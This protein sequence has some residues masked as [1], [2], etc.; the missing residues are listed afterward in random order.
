MIRAFP[1]QGES[2]R[3][4]DSIYIEICIN[5]NDGPLHN[6]L[7]QYPQYAGN[8]E[9]AQYVKSLLIQAHAILEQRQMLSV[10]MAQS[11]VAMMNAPVTL[12]RHKF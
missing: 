11:T 7:K 9:R 4:T 2:M 12:R 6:K 1:E 3:K 5:P 10:P 8:R